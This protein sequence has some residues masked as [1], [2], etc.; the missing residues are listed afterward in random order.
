MQTP[1]LSV[2][3]LSGSAPS[4]ALSMRNSVVPASRTPRHPAGI[5]AR[6]DQLA[7]VERGDDFQEKVVVPLIEAVTIFQDKCVMCW[8]YRKTAWTGHTS[9]NCPGGVGTNRGDPEYSIFRESAFKLPPG[10]CY[11]CLIHQVTFYFIF[12]YWLLI[13]FY[14]QRKMNHPFVSPLQCPWRGIITRVAYMFTRLNIDCPYIRGDLDVMDTSQFRL[15]L[16]EDPLD[17]AGFPFHN[18]LKLFLWII[19]SHYNLIDDCK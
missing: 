1:S 16:S 19:S 3:R 5:Q 8:M 13:C 14:F 18:G 6:Q 10:W 11:P 7:A 15:W 2:T 17:Y 12:I 9:D 4:S